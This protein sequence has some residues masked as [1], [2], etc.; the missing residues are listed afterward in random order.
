MADSQNVGYKITGWHMKKILLLIWLVTGIPAVADD[1]VESTVTKIG[2]Q[3]PNFLIKTLEG[4]EIDLAELRGR[5]VLL[6]FFAT[7]CSPCLQE[8]PHLELDV[9][10]RFKNHDFFLIAIGR[11]HTKRELVTFTNIVTFTFPIAADPKR[12]IY[13]RFA[14]K[15]I[16]RNILIDKTGTII[17]QSVGYSKDEFQRIIDKI[18]EA[19]SQ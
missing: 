1:K 11:E 5:V 19:L 15:Y 4:G 2:Q 9:W 16:P 7:W 12:E 8:L 14:T 10:Q 18:E 6:N 17:Y 13:S 3:A